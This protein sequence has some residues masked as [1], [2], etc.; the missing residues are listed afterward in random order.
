MASSLSCS[1]KKKQAV[2]LLISL[3]YEKK[4]IASVLT[5]LYILSFMVQV[6]RKIVLLFKGR[7]SDEGD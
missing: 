1:T 3:L 5:Q 7:V 4:F 2:I 6:K